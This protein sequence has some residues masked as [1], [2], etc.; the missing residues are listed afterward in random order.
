MRNRKEKHW[1]CWPGHKITFS[2][3]PVVSEK[4]EKAVS[5]Q[6]TAI[7][8]LRKSLKKKGKLVGCWWLQTGANRNIMFLAAVA[9]KK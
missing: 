2:I 6:V 4:P 5:S 7:Q 1:E 9:H 3:T 8:T